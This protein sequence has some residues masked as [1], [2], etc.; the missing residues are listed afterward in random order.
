MSIINRL[1]RHLRPR[2]EKIFGA[3]PTVRL[4]DAAKRRVMR[5]AHTYNEKNRGPGQHRGPLTRATLDVLR[6]LLWGF[7]NNGRPCFPSYETIAAKAKCHRD[8]VYTAIVAL[9]ASGLLTWVNRIMRATERVRDLF[10]QMVERVT[11]HRRSNAYTFSDPGPDAPPASQWQT[12]SRRDL[13][14]ENTAGVRNLDFSL[15]S[16]DAHDARKRLAEIAKRRSAEILGR[17]QTQ[18]A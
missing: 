8:T 14:S 13:K 18:T 7:P 3:G 12:A 9:E 6:A 11:V 1:P 2:R 15:S 16:Y 17:F 10:G 4:D 5:A